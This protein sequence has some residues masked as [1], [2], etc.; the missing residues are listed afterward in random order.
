MFQDITDQD[1]TDST[2][3][4]GF[5]LFNNKEVTI[6]AKLLTDSFQRRTSHDQYNRNR[7]R[8]ANFEKFG[9]LMLNRFLGIE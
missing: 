3:Q 1:A 9:I 7:F 4:C 2:A 6:A 5:F 8:T